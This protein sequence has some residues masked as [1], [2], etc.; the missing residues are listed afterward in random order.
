MLLKVQVDE[1][2][3]N[4]K[5][6]N[7]LEERSVL[8]FRSERARV[9][10]AIWSFLL[11]ARHICDAKIEP[12]SFASAYQ[13]PGHQKTAH[14]SR[15]ALKFLPSIFFSSLL[16]A[17]KLNHCC[18]GTASFPMFFNWSPSSKGVEWKAGKQP[19][20][21]ANNVNKQQQATEYNDKWKDLQI[22]WAQVSGVRPRTRWYL[23]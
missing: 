6:R 21:G 4:W 18:S 13:R 11:P 19:W 1:E 5:W 16:L 2:M 8:D 15:L 14:C 12:Q 23:I 7:N 17:A 20:M 10:R 22:E 9:S 3:W